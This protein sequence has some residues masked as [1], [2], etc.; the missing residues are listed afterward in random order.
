MIC[1]HSCSVVQ[2]FSGHVTVI[3]WVQCLSAFT[4]VW[5]SYLRWRRRVRELHHW[6]S[7]LQEEDHHV[8]I[9][10]ACKRLLSWSLHLLMMSPLQRLHGN[11]HP[12]GR[13][14]C[15][16]GLPAL[17]TDAHGG[18]TTGEISQS[19][20]CWCDR[21]LQRWPLTPWFSIKALFT[22]HWKALLNRSAPS[23][24]DCVCW[25]I[26]THGLRRRKVLQ[27]WEVSIT[28]LTDVIWH[29]LRWELEELGGGCPS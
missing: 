18:Q 11:R 28:T 26:K 8:S 15:S 16:G 25:G 29:E 5:S 9:W 3:I 27:S 7:A 19:Q 20:Y 17:Y 4:E 22:E 13:C 10:H 14:V 23:D 24:L 6:L 1:L 21:C 12:L 2:W